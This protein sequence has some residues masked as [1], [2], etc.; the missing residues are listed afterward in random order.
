MAIPPPPPP[1]FITLCGGH[2][3]FTFVDKNDGDFFDTYIKP[4]NLSGS[5]LGSSM[6][7]RNIEGWAQLRSTDEIR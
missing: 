3:G 7:E 2:C 6:V 4:S 5:G 1:L